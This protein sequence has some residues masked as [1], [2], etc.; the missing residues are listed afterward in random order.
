MMMGLN[1]V[2]FDGWRARHPDKK[3]AGFVF[4]QGFGIWAASTIVYLLFAGCRKARGIVA[5][6]GPLSFEDVTPH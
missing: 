5:A 1:S 6:Y 2:P 3:K 4:A